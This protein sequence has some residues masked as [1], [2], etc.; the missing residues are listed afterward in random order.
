MYKRVRYNIFILLMFYR[1][2]VQSRPFLHI[3]CLGSNLN[4]TYIEIPKYEFSRFDVDYIKVEFMKIEISQLV[5][6]IIS[7][8]LAEKLEEFTLSVSKIT[9][10]QA[11]VFDGL[12]LRELRLSMCGIDNNL[13]QTE[14]F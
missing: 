11:N 7:P 5:L 13:L 2:G 14:L 12:H 1:L 9:Q 10:I 8:Q 3:Y 6:P 4:T